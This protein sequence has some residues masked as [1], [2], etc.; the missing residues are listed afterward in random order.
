LFYG[1]KVYALVHQPTRIVITAMLLPGNQSNQVAAPVLSQSI[2]GGVLLGDQGYREEELFDWLCEK[3]DT[4]RLMTSDDSSDAD[5]R[6][7]A[8]QPRGS[9]E[10]AVFRAPGIDLGIGSTSVPGM[11]S[12]QA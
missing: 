7:W 11:G 5:G 12:G 3:A 1:F 8:C 6:P 9:R 4:L 10:G 2:G